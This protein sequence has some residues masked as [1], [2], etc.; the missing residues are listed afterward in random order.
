MK[1]SKEI[2]A[3]YDK[4]AVSKTGLSAGKMVVSG[5]FAGAFIAFG[6]LGSQIAN[7]SIADAGIGRY[8]G[9]L[10]FPVGLMMVLTVGTELFTGNCLMSLP[11]LRGKITPGK[12]L[13]SWCLVYLGNFI[14]SLMVA[15]LAV[16]GGLPSF[17]SGALAETMVSN[18]AAK[19]SLSV[20]AGIMRGILCNILVCLAVWISFGADEMAGK[21]M[22][23]FLPT[24][25][26]VLCGF[27]HSIAN[28][29][30]IP[31]GMMSAAQYGITAD[32]TLSGF[33]INNLLPVTIGNIIG[34]AG[35]VGA[36][37]YIL[38]GRDA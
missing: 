26:F 22:G 32:I 15:G 30:F 17:F 6:G 11:L 2:A 27:E 1:N 10:V 34:G 35:F 7:A 8:V 3:F 38:F 36:G 31:A 4:A 5:I 33:L 18:A 37:L 9:A 29:Y 16:Y 14:G 23:L 24:M 20:S 25:L 12:M 19:A 28:M 21:I 13:K